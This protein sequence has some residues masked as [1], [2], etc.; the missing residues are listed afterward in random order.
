MIASALFYFLV[1]LTML[2][3]LLVV[4]SRNVVTSTFFMIITFLGSAGLF[5][6]LNAYF[7]A[8]LQVL[9][10]AGAIMVL[11]L[12]VVMLIDVDKAPSKESNFFQ[13]TVG[14]AIGSLLVGAAY[15]IFIAYPSIPSHTVLTPGMALA[16]SNTYC[17]IKEMS[18]LL[19]TK[20]MLPVQ[21]IGCLLFIA[22]I[23]VVVISKPFISAEKKSIS[24]QPGETA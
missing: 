8:I 16:D 5:V 22:M 23:G 13:T 9:V 11:F 2:S 15:H 12:F 21:V 17:S 14:A 4:C 7:L 18:L 1:I 20:Y 6:F 24:K 10:Y 19:L 3:A